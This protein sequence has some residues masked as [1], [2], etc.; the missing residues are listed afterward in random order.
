MKS[1]KQLLMYAALLLIFVIGTGILLEQYRMY[2]KAYQELG[3]MIAHTSIDTELFYR[4]E[5]NEECK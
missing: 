1:V 3:R 5:G 4:E 2:K